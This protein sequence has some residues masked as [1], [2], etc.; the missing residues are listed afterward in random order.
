MQAP[1][2]ISAVA[3]ERGR[4]RPLPPSGS[5]RGDAGPAAGPPAL[6][7]APPATRRRD[8][9]VGKLHALAVADAVQRRQLIR[10]EAPR[11]CQDGV[12]EVLA[13]PRESARGNR[14]AKA[15]DVLQGEGY[16]GHRRAIHGRLL[17]PSYTPTLD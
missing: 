11:F 13:E 1:F 2:H 10:R 15:G 17:R 3:A 5:G 12:D 14:L 16:L 6:V 4:G 8:D 7:D 9:A